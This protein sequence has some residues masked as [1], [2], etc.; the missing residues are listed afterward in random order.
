MSKTEIECEHLISVKQVA[1]KTGLSPMTIR[2]MHA[3]GRIPKGV[4]L[5]R[6]IKWRAKEIDDWIVSGCKSPSVAN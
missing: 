6:H 3:D 1:K 5:C 4:A 2:R